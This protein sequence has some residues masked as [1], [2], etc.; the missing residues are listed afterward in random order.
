MSQTT[1]ALLARFGLAQYPVRETGNTVLFAV[2]AEELP[3]VIRNLK[4]EHR[5][6][7]KTV[8]ATEERK[9][10]GA[11]RIYYV[12]GVPAT[13]HSQRGEL[14]EN[15]FLVPFLSVDRDTKTFPSLTPLDQEFSVYEQEIKTFFGLSPVGH[16]QA[17]RISCMKKTTKPRC[18]LF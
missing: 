2:S 9:E 11:F 14:E 8:T 5:L 12:F 4:H 6:P 3:T 7:L 15:I 16:P 10:K 13:L 17:K 18:T 1:T